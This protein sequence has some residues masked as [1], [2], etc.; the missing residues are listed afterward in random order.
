M[1]ERQIM[2]LEFAGSIP[3]EAASNESMASIL[4]CFCDLHG[5]LI[6]TWESLAFRVPREHETAGSNP[7]V[8]TSLIR[9]GQTVRQ[10]PVKPTSGGSSPPTG[11]FINGRAS[12]LAMA[13]ASKAVER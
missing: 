1:G 2:D 5:L 11:A 13:A 12:Q 7:A 6:R 3:V 8:L 9:C 4:S 10:R